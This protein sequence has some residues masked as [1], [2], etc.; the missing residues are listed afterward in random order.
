MSNKVAKVTDTLEDMQE[1][2][3]FDIFDD[4]YNT[5]EEDDDDDVSNY[6]R[7]LEEESGDEEHDG[8]AVY[9]DADGP[10]QDGASEEDTSDAQ[11]KTTSYNF[12]E[13]EEQ[14]SSYSDS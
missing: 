5:E 12:M 7:E 8:E 9:S 14:D 11:L 1:V 3:A 2:M 13:V 4:Q 6:E 10:F